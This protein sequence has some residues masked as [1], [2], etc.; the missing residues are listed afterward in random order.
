MRKPFYALML[1]FFTLLNGVTIG[2]NIELISR[3]ENIDIKEDS[4]FVKRVSIKFKKLQNLEWYSI[5]YD[6]HL[7]EVSNIN[8]FIQKGKRLKKID[9]IK[10]I[11]ERAEL[12]YITSQ[13]IKII[14]IPQESDVLLTYEVTSKEL[15]YLTSLPLFSH[16]PTDTLSY[17][18]SLPQNFSL[19]HNTINS[20]LLPVFKIDSTITDYNSVYTI[21][22]IPL[23]VEPN[24]LQ[25]FGI[26]R[27]MEV[28]LMRVLVTTKEYKNQPKRYLNDWYLN[29]IS[30]TKTLSY[31]AKM[32]IDELTLRVT[33]SLKITKIIYDYVKS[34]FKYVAIEIGMGAFIP[35]HVN[36]VYTNKQ[37]D[38]KDLSNFLS[39]ALRYKG[40]RS[41]LAL[42]ATFDHITDCDFPS[43][44]SANHVI[45]IAYINDEVIL[46]DP[47]D[48]IHTQGTPVESLQDRTILIINPEGGT[49]HKVKPFSPAQ[50]KIS[51]LIDVKENEQG[52]TLE[53]TFSVDYQG[54][55]SNYMRRVMLSKNT[56]DFHKFGETFYEK[57]LGNQ[58]ISN[59]EIL[60][61]L[62]NL[63]FG[64]DLSINGK[65]FIDNNNTYLFL[66]F[67]PRLI[68][69]EDRETL[70][71]GTHLNNPYRKLL[72][73]SIELQDY[74][75]PFKPIEHK[76]QE[77]GV[78]LQ[79]MIQ[80]TSDKV[81]ECSYD[82][83]FTNY[84]IEENNLSET[85]DILKVFKKIIN[86]PI[87]ITHKKN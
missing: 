4:S 30:D 46:L 54:T 34:N 22:S 8:V 42:A 64:G 44:S 75:A 7:E 24:P 56:E 65:T 36:E 11:E 18:I 43:L 76:Y 73:A 17:K 84:F 47:T 21:E 74:M 16:I 50:N 60:T 26:Y 39:E 49:F 80:R 41:D 10:I 82:F 45:A 9:N 86:D 37:G 70:I 85:N 2:Q 5:F 72:I 25:F 66:D 81:I 33:D 27:N 13:K 63:K 78:S 48:P 69:T 87:L 38:C 57:V 67:L 59:F 40:I 58:S 83:V 15:M 68:E 35:S 53:G 71:K 3:F 77:E 32:K 23:I 1:L 12:D 19:A 79:V 31:E 61:D 6:S 20:E 14:S 62:N 28:P 55:S 51:Y 52:G 29:S